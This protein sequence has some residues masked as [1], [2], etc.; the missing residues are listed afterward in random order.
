MIRVTV[1]RSGEE[2]RGFTCS[3]HADYASQGQDIICAA[4][5]ALVI[6]AVNSLE[7]FSEDAFTVDQDV[8]SGGFLKLT[9]HDKNSV[10]ARL[11]MDSLVLG[12]QSIETSY[13]KK[14]LSLKVKEEPQHS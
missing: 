6:N 7:Q 12:L 5:S 9:L 1:F 10:Q 8:Q 14:Y 4:V 11:L 3:G 13:G 2:Y